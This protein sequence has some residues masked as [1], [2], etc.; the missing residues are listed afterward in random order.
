MP[1][2]SATFTPSTN[3]WNIGIWFGV[4]V[5]VQLTPQWLAVSRFASTSTF[6]NM[7][8]GNSAAIASKAGAIFWQGPHHFAVK[9]MTITRWWK[10]VKR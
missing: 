5:R 2:V 7:T 3:S 4:L 9:S 8:E 10:R 1:F 6:A